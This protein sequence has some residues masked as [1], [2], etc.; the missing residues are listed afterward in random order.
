MQRQFLLVLVV[1]LTAG[2]LIFWPPAN[3]SRAH[4]LGD[5]SQTGGWT[6]QTSGTTN[7]LRSVNFVSENEGWAAG[8]NATLLRT[9]NGGS[10]WTPVNTGAEPARGFNAVRFL[11]QNTGW[12]SGASV[13]ARTLNAGTNWTVVVLPSAN[14]ISNN[15]LHSALFPISATEVW[16]GGE[17]NAQSS[18]I[19]LGTVINYDLATNG[20]LTRQTSFGFSIANGATPNRITDLH[21]TDPRVSL[22]VGN[23]GLIARTDL[24][25]QQQPFTFP[26]SGTSQPLNAIQMLDANNGW[27]SGNGGTILKTTNGGEIWTP[28]SSGTTANLRDV[29]F[30]DANRGWAV[31]D[32]GVIVTTSNG[33]GNW[34]PEPSG[35]TADLRAVHFASANAGYAVGVNGTILRRSG[36][37]PTQSTVTTVSAASFT[38]GILASESIAA[39]FGTALATTTESATT[40]PLPTTLAGATVKVRDSQNIERSAPLFF[41]SPGQINFQIPPGSAVG[42][43]SISV[44]NGQGATATGTLQIAA[45]AP[46]VFTANATGQ[47]VAAA[48]ALRVRADGSQ[49]FESVSR[50]DA[51]QNHFVSVPIDMGPATDQIFLLLFGTGVRN[52]SA[53]SAVTATIG[54]ETSEVS[55]A[56][57]QTDFVGLDQINVRVP[58]SLAGRG[59][60]D[61]VFTADSRTANTVR[62]NIGNGSSS[63]TAPV[64]AN[65]TLNNPTMNGS[66]A[67]ISGRFDFTDADG[68]IAFNGNVANSAYVRFMVVIGQNGCTGGVTGF[69]LHFPGQTSGTINFSGTYNST[70]PFIQPLSVQIRLVDVAGR[71]SNALTGNVN[72]W[73]C[74]LPAEFE[75]SP[76]ADSLIEPAWMLRTRQWREL[77]G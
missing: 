52:R 45:V 40:V 64:I 51:G 27:V 9:T 61:V 38:G 29:H 76:P 77:V 10:S 46:G 19:P 75:W 66:T 7:E 2:T 62:V 24:N 39:A 73:F 65:L 5:I 21:F 26:N 44:T 15:V 37:T 31:G 67:T 58:R 72:Q 74:G 8:A 3:V 70:T 36:T 1:L 56:G 28:Q 68:D 59:E 63:G 47:G 41:V 60:V 49:S 54:G 20:V 12:A 23:V 57:V 55:Y 48:V 16:T 4:T 6:A 33:G 35:T 42:A 71:F 22:A 69:F 32:G 14:P 50:F 34:A 25:N 53:I 43:A 17:G 13:L 30:V 11:D 18:G